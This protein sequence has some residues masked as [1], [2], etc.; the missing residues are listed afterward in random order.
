M[1]NPAEIDKVMEHAARTESLAEEIITAKHQVV[2]FDR[3]RNENRLAINELQKKSLKNTSRVW[4]NF[5]EIFLKLPR[6]Q[7]NDMV[8]Q[9]QVE[10]TAS[11]GEVRTAIQVKATELREKEGKA[12]SKGWE[13]KGMPFKEM[14]GPAI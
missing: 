12:I 9:D 11:I 7:V 10:L 4:T 6:H 1:R 8:E 3:R 13:L 14:S 2:E 5:G